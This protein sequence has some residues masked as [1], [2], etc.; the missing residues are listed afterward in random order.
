MKN[1]SLWQILA[2]YAG[3][4]WV[5]LQVV[6]VVKDNM[7]LPDWVFPFALLL[8]LIGLPIIV[9][10]AVVQ[11]RHAVDGSAD[12]ASGEA[13]ESIPAPASQ[14]ELSPRR[15]FTWRNALV[16]GGLAFVLLTAV[17][18]GFMF[19][20][21]QGIGPVGSLVAKGMLDEQAAVVVADFVADDP[22]LARAVTQAFRVDLSQ[23]ELIKV[24]EPATLDEALAR[25]EL[26]EDQAITHQIAHE[27]A[28]R[29]GYPAVI[30]GEVSSIGDGFVLTARLADARSEETLASLRETAAD[31]NEVIPAIDRLSGKMRERIG[32]SYSDMRAEDPLA[33]VTTGSL[34]A[35]EKYSQALDLFRSGR[36][37][38]L[39]VELLEEAVAIDTAFAMAWR[40]IGVETV[41]D[42]ARIVEAMEKAYLFRDRLTERESLLAEASYYTTVTGEPQRAIR[43]YERMVDLDPAD[44]WALNN[45]GAAYTDLGEWAEAEHWFARSVAVDSSVKSIN[46][47]ATAQINQGKLDEAEATLEIADR[48]APGSERTLGTRYSLETNRENW[49]E[50]EA[51]ALQLRD[52]NSDPAWTSIGS[53][54]LGTVAAIE[55]KLAEAESSWRDA[56]RES[57]QAGDAF[58]AWPLMQVFDLNVHVRRDTARA[59]RVLDAI[60]AEYPLEGMDVMNRPYGWL[61]YW[62]ARAGDRATAESLIA[63]MEAEVPTEY[64]SG[65]AV[66]DFRRNIEVANLMSE[67][68]YEAALEL[69]RQVDLPGCMQCRY[70]PKAQIFDQLGA[71]DSALA[72]YTGY[73]EL[74]AHD[75][76]GWD[77]ELRG[78][79]LERVGQLYDEAGDLENAAVY[80]A[81][82]VDL[83]AE[84]D[85]ELQPRV[86]AARTRLEEIIRERG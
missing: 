5:V 27:L 25:M 29:E 81:R 6:D 3:A 34:E 43:V 82:F 39:G 63:E 2:L 33:D 23:S 72:M 38:Q 30:E 28:V 50:A 26:P 11:G 19:M 37:R 65:E 57:S 14:S 1:R 54:A 32:D 61:A 17:T 9:A 52:E 58:P 7:G 21:N 44:A 48:L 68:R 55:G 13:A 35:L 46:N 84:A 69:V 45:L 78:P 53:L 24:V 42:R 67:G 71:R 49:A 74:Y 51:A 10:T 85:A 47:V 60:L 22:S 83:W 20:R 76:A 73:L 77:N 59:L 75:R 36:D 56:V 70:V 18:T 79:T 40:K 31:A 8:L 4:S 66:D 80:Y 41:G 64:R 86:D 12:S 15:L 16:G 62:Y